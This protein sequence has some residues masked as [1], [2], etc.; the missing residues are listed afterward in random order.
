MSQC[1]IEKYYTNSF[2]LVIFQYEV[3]K[4]IGQGCPFHAGA[5]LMCPLAFLDGDSIEE[6]GGHVLYQGGLVG[7]C[8]YENYNQYISFT[9]NLNLE[10]IHVILN[11]VWWQSFCFTTVPQTAPGM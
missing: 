7:V 4:P 2:S 5:T 3:P 1:L 8:E 10:T 9:C 6:L 11:E